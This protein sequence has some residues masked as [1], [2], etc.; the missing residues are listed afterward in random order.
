MALNW[1]KSLLLGGFLAAALSLPGW[2]QD[3]DFYA[4]K[5]EDTVEKLALRQRISE[6][7][8][9]KLNPTLKG[10][11]LPPPGTVIFLPCAAPLPPSKVVHHSSGHKHQEVA[12]QTESSEPPSRAGQGVK[13]I[14]GGSAGELSDDEVDALYENTVKPL[15]GQL[16]EL[17]QVTYSALPDHQNVVTTSDGEIIHVP[18]A[19]SQPKAH[20]SEEEVHPR[21]SLSSRRGIQAQAVLRNALKFLGV[22]YVWGGVSPTGFDCSGFVQHVYASCGI[23]LPRTADL[24]FNIGRVVPAGKEQPGDLIF[25]ETYCPGP[26]HIG[27]FLGRHQFCHASSGAGHITISDLREAHFQRCYIGAKRVF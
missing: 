19:R 12:N 9:L 10:G 20:K 2:A 22:P 11:L 13:E 25:F 8:I 5:P 16:A 18:Q 27:I 26:S 23:S 1:K 4:V 15:G 21:S 17:A 6:E 14:R 24:Q 7:S 3:Y